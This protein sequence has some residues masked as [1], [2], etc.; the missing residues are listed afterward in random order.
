MS[1]EPLACP[2]CNALVPVA[3]GAFQGQR[4]PCPRCGEA[5]TLRQPP[6]SGSAR[7]QVIPAA[8]TAPPGVDFDVERR[9][10][11]GR[12]KH[13]TAAVVLGVMGLMAAVGLAFAL[14]T[15]PDRR[16]HDTA[17]PAPH[18]RSPLQDLPETPPPAVTPPA[19]LEALHGCR[20]IAPS[21]PASKSPSCARPTPA[22]TC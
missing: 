13:L 19:A 2:Y 20:R 3:P 22:A 15:V 9:V 1:N 4:V 11:A 16:A 6:L 18:R 5:F 14:Y 12:Y 8:V 17:M 10:R 21:S 7:V